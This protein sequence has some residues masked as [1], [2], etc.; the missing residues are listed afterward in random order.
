MTT[1]TE[2]HVADLPA[3]LAERGIKI[4]YRL[5]VAAPK[6]AVDANIKNLLARHKPTLVGALAR[7]DSFGN[8]AIDYAHVLTLDRQGFDWATGEQ[9]RQPGDDDDPEP[10]RAAP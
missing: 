3:L 1:P 4:G 8:P 6:G 7:A 9:H 5:T 10:A 2:I